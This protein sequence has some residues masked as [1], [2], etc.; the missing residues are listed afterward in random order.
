MQYFVKIGVKE[1]GP[2]TPRLLKALADNR[3]IKPTDYIRK[4]NSDQ[5]HLAGQVKGLFAESDKEAEPQSERSAEADKQPIVQISTKTRHIPKTGSAVVRISCIVTAVVI[6]ASI[7][8]WFTLRE[9][10]RTAYRNIVAHAEAGEWEEVW[11]R[12]DRKSQAKIEVS[13]EMMAG[14]AAAFDADDD[15][16]LRSLSG[17]KLFLRIAANN[18]NFRNQY[19]D[20]EVD[21]VEID[22]DHATLDVWVSEAGGKGRSKSQVAMLHEDGMW[23]LTME[24]QE[25]SDEAT[26]DNVQAQQKTSQKA[27]VSSPI[28]LADPDFRNVKWGMSSENVRRQETAE[29]VHESPDTLGYKETIANSN[30]TVLYIFVDNMLVRTKY[31]ITERHS[32]N[33]EHITDYESLGMLLSQKYGSPTDVKILWK[34]DLYKDDPAEYGTA[35][36]VGHLSMYEEWDT[37]ITTVF[38]YLNGDNFAIKHGVEYIGK[39]YEKLEDG[40]RTRETLDDL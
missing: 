21:S 25:T 6:L 24:G 10:P 17:K 27:E 8:V 16:T 23:K 30:C 32:N 2:V 7:T 3:Q 38:H 26:V 15:G 35:I 18:E 37:P 12:I 14:M 39:A 31:V 11:N 1:N 22:G 34:N 5:W 4:A 36:A 29:L 13:L 33:T 20:R 19:L 40:A 9:T 28:P